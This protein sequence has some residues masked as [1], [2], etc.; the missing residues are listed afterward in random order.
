[1]NWNLSAFTEPCIRCSPWGF[2]FSLHLIFD[3]TPCS[4]LYW[5]NAWESRR[6]DCLPRT[7]KNLNNKLGV[8]EKL[9]DSSQFSH[10]KNKY[11]RLSEI[12]DCFCDLSLGPIIPKLWFSLGLAWEWGGGSSMHPAYLCLVFTSWIIVPISIKIKR[13]GEKE[14]NMDGWWLGA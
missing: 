9:H 14:K 8:R 11:I 5:W 6:V 4:R 7:H 1:M 12:Q 3:L 10:L 13:K 2:L